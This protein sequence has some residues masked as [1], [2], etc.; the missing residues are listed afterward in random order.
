M[1]IIV[2][3][4]VI[5]GRFDGYLSVI[6]E[7]DTRKRQSSNPSPLPSLRSTFK[8]IISCSKRWHN[9]C[10]NG[11]RDAIDPADVVP[12]LLH[13]I[14]WFQLGLNSSFV[15]LLLLLLGFLF[16]ESPVQRNN[17]NDNKQK[18]YG[19]N[20]GDVRW[21][22]FCA[23]SRVLQTSS[24]SQE[25][26]GPDTSRFRRS[27]KTRANL[28]GGS[29]RRGSLPG[30]SI[31]CFPPPPP[32]VKEWIPDD[33]LKIEKKNHPFP[34][35][36]YWMVAVRARQDRVAGSAP[37]IDDLCKYFPFWLGRQ[38]RCI[39]IWLRLRCARVGRFSSSFSS[40]SS[41]LSFVWLDPS[42]AMW[43]Q[44]SWLIIGGGLI[45]SA[46]AVALPVAPQLPAAVSKK[47]TS[48][49]FQAI[50]SPS[51]SSSSSSSSFEFS[52]PFLSA[53]WECV[54]VCVC[55]CASLVF[56]L[57]QLDVWCGVRVIFNGGGQDRSCQPHSA[58]SL[59]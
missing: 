38:I 40:S 4:S 54:C 52:L 11:R 49:W 48:K 56:Q 44:F 22:L 7:P 25:P 34:V 10:H 26:P 28:A 1:V 12:V 18:Y 51:S 23:P 19:G 15:L 59:L 21:R 39:S 13:S 31:V 45:P 57:I 8:R 33:N 47:K 43:R 20:A 6:Q 58:S 37:L 32:G 29:P 17:I 30:I 46:A 2:D 36:A 53:F 27:N 55:V 3:G 50:I 14:G 42:D 24:K 35:M 9:G 41:F 16:H 5:Y